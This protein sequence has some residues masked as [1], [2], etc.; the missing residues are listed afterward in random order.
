MNYRVYSVSVSMQ[1]TLRLH[2]SSLFWYTA[3]LVTLVQIP[4]LVPQNTCGKGLALKKNT[5][6]MIIINILYNKYSQTFTN[7]HL[8][9]K[10]QFILGPAEGDFNKLIQNAKKER[11]LFYQ[12]P[13]LHNWNGH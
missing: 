8:C 11:R 1:I 3:I 9:L 2:F 5:I 10:Q 13:P 12:R 4:K 7:S 6:I